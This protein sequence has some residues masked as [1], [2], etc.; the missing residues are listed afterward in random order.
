MDGDLDGFRQEFE[1]F[2][3][4]CPF[5]LYHVSTGRF[6]PVF[7]FSMF[8]TAHDANILK[9]NERVYFRFDNHGIDTGGRNRNTGNLKVAVYHDGQ[10]VVRCYSISDRLNSDGLRFSTRERNALVRE[11]RGQNPNLREEDLNFEQYKVCMHGKGKS[12]GEA[13]ATV[14]EVIREKDSQGRDRFAKYSA[15]EI[16]LLR[17]IE[18]NRLNG[19]NA[20]APRS[21]LTVKEIGS[22]RLNQDQRVQLGHLVNFVQVAPGQQGIFSFME[23]LASNQ[24]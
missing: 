8:A 13:I 12:Q 7:F 10:Q 18:R 17:H 21:L 5:F 15:S 19:I 24:K 3:D 14:F 23:V 1:S 2:L 20:P 4:Q 11:I 16:S 22:I 6:L 9:A